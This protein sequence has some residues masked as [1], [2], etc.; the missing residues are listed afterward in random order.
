MSDNRS[1][2]WCFTIN[3]YTELDQHIVFEMAEYTK[4]VV[5]GR[6]IGTENETPHLQGFVYFDTVKSLKQ[7]KDIHETAHWESMRGTVD[8]A[9]QYCMKDGDYFESG[10]K[11]LSDKEKGSFGKLSIEERWALA[12]AGEFELLP[13]EHIK[14]YQYVHSKY[15]TV[16]DRDVLDNIWVQGFSGCGKSRWVRDTYPTFFVKSM[17]KWWDG[18]NGEEV[19]VLD[20]FDPKHAEFLSYYL[21]IWADRYVFNAEVKGGMMSIR[22]KTFIITSQYAIEDCFQSPQDI[23]AIAR[24]FVVH[25]LAPL[26]DPSIVPTTIAPIFKL[27]R[28]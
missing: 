17:S 16:A 21:K 6:E 25:S 8:Q 1:R 12:K 3:N 23:A 15:R 7:M 14:I 4:Y 9:A 19:V 13:P 18:Y 20:D 27:H 2:A 11:P 28:T 22:P 26:N 10:V 24:R 5:C